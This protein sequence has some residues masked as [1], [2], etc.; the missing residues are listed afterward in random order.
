M[1]K[2]NDLINRH[3]QIYRKLKAMTAIMDLAMMVFEIVKY[4]TIEGLHEV[5]MNQA[6]GLINILEEQS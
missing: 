3:E 5:M 4:E 2:G 1:P 6:R